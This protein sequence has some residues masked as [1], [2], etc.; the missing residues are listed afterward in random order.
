[1]AAGRADGVAL[2]ELFSC[3]RDGDGGVVVAVVETG[4]R[5]TVSLLG[6][7]RRMQYTSSLVCGAPTA[8]YL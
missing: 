5:A 3:V 6:P 8:I 4:V 2:F 1:M 7:Q